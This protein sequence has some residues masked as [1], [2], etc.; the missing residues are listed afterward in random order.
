VS[1]HSH[2]LPSRPATL[3]EAEVI[4]AQLQEK[5]QLA[6][7]RLLQAE[8][9][10]RLR[11]IEKYGPGSEKLSS[12]QLEM[13]EEE[14]GISNVEVQAES[15]RPV[16][17]GDATEVLVREHKRRKH[18]GRQ[19]LPADLPRVERV[20]ACAPEQ[21]VCGRCGQPTQVIG[22]EVSEQLAVEPAK[23]FV[24]VT[25]REKRA[26]MCGRSGV[27]TAAL[28]ARIIAKGL[29]SDS[30]VLDTVVSKYCDHLPLYRQ[31]RMLQ[32]EAGLDL[33]RVTLD[34]WVMQVG[35]LLVPMVK[36]MRKELLRGGYIQADETPVDVQLHDGRGRNHQA[37]LWQYSRPG[38]AVIFDFRLGRGRDGPK[39]FLGDYAGL[40]Q[41]DGYQAYEQV[42][43]ARLVHAAC[44]THARRGFSNV[45][46]L[47]PGDP[48][49]LPIV[50]KINELFAIDAIAR[51]ERMTLEQR[52]ALR[53]ERAPAVLNALK[54]MIE[55]AQA[56]AL[57]GC[58][59]GKACQYTLGLWP[60]L[61][62]FLEH[63]Q[64]ELSNNLAENS[65]RP[66]ALGRKNWI[67]VGSQ[68]AGPKVAAILS[69]VESCRRLKIPVR[70][71]LASVLPGL[72]DSSI[73]RLAELTPSAW[74]AQSR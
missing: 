19:T 46:K 17:E 35:Q 50:E 49:A 51:D 27:V 15:E 42:G 10:L 4:I 33:S 12:L 69:I 71:Y 28:P 11:R 67:H 3:S 64:L 7:L 55:Q 68:Q 29:V 47:N 21:C 13:L 45:V 62:R 54:A 1:T 20:I 39:Q 18:P 30:V 22:F 5:L 14:P 48:G 73:R 25:K 74:L 70:E 8:E 38:G 32:R 6:E 40:L 9:R 31:S 59:L 53:Q 2:P 52:Y 44:W 65:M 34:G 24:Q 41:T 66:V 36:F 16:I 43:G 57:P 37:Y 56:G 61:T 72:A 60:K 23:Y 63:P 58:A 26:C